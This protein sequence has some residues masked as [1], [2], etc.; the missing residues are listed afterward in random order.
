MTA[1][2]AR[3]YRAPVVWLGAAILFLSLA[4][5]I[6]LILSATRYPD[7]SLVQGRDAILKV[8]TSRAPEPAGDEH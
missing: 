1:T 5:C 3:W 2:R 8:P 4:G 7:Q 6:A